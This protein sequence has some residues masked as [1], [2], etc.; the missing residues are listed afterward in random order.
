LTRREWLDGMR[1]H[2]ADLAHVYL[3]AVASSTPPNLDVVA[4][5]FGMRSALADLTHRL[6]EVPDAARP[7][8]MPFDAETEAEERG[9]VWAPPPKAKD[10]VRPT[11]EPDDPDP[12]AERLAI[13]RTWATLTHSTADDG[14]LDR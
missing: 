13:A 6:D 2:L 5:L 10:T 3:D 1:G 12:E 11:G 9:H 7:K 8:A 14:G 4:W